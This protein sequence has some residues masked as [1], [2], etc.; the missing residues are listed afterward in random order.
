[1][2]S[3]KILLPADRTPSSC[4][5]PA[6]LPTAPRTGLVN[7]VQGYKAKANY[8]GGGLADALRF[9]AQMIVGGVNASVY[10][11]SLGGFDTHTNQ[12]GRPGQPAQTAVRRH[13][14]FS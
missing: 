14:C 7:I 11:L 9:V 13:R 5:K 1:M 12:K 8:P 2:I 6:W 10:N 3:I 4:V